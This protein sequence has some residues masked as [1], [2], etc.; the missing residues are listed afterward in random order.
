MNTLQIGSLPI[1]VSENFLVTSPTREY[2]QGY[3][4]H[5]ELESGA[6]VRALIRHFRGQLI[7]LTQKV[8]VLKVT[9]ASGEFHLRDALEGEALN[10]NAKY[11][12]PLH[13]DL[14]GSVEPQEMQRHLYSTA[15][16]PEY[17]FSGTHA[18]WQNATFEGR[19]ASTVWVPSSVGAEATLELVTTPTIELVESG[20]VKE[21]EL[22][23]WDKVTSMLARTFEK[24]G[25]SPVA[26]VMVLKDLFNFIAF[27]LKQG[28]LTATLLNLFDRITEHVL[29]QVKPWSL[30]IDWSTREATQGLVC[31]SDAGQLGAEKKMLHAR[32]NRGNFM[33]TP[34]VKGCSINVI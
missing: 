23:L 22:E 11:S 34:T 12:L 21:E 24:V 32:R 31:L 16:C 25:S 5:L 15:F 2:P 13:V 33:G 14:A 7:V 29:E 20:L 27:K 26:Q 17:W 6:H 3:G 1:K 9:S 18:F 10:F 4:L 19:N 28:S 30:E 8:G